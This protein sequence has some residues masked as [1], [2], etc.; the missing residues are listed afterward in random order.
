MPTEA[1]ARQL[2]QTI[3]DVAGSAG[4]PTMAVL[5]DMDQP[6]GTTIGNA[7]EV[8][9]AIDVLQGAAGPVR[10]LT[11]ELGACLLLQ[12]GVADS[13]AAA[14]SQL[15]RMIDSGAA[16]ERF[17]RMVRAQGGKLPNRFP[18]ATGH[19]IMATES[20]YIAAF[21]SRRI[22]ETVVAIGGGR[23][24]Q[25]DPI[26]HSVGVK[27]HGRIGDRIEQ[28][29]PIFTLHCPAAMADDYADKLREAVSISTEKVDP[30]PLIIR[31]ITAGESN[32]AATGSEQ[33]QQQAQQPQ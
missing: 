6:L 30:R 31:R 1:K 20:G 9:E 5:S 8:Q 32:T 10:D 11:I 7:L 13:P 28:G 26:D 15:A 16:R 23:R 4:L 3:V 22:G 33:A 24:R 12:T 17:E 21:D 18:I 19:E 25:G 14:R 29:T 2:A 27:V